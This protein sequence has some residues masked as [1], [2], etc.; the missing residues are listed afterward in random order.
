MFIIIISIFLLE[1]CTEKE[2]GGEVE[3]RF[4]KNIT[5]SID[6]GEVVDAERLQQLDDNRYDSVIGGLLLMDESVI[7][8]IIEYM[9]ENGYSIKPGQY[10]FNQ[11][12]RFEKG[13][14]VLNNGEKREIFKFQKK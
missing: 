11:S 10:T 6:D 14:F 3:M 13:K 5:I 12:W 4:G 9:R 2:S 1:G 7:K 8:A